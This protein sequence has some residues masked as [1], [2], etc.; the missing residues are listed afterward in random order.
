VDRPPTQS[1]RSELERLRGSLYD[2]AFADIRRA[3]ESELDLA[4]LAFVGLASWIDTL[5]L[6][7]TGGKGQGPEAWGRFFSR[8]VPR[9]RDPPDAKLLSH[10]FRNALLHEYGTRQVA[11]THGRPERHW[12]LDGGIRTLDLGTLLDEFDAAFESFYADLERDTDLRA[13]AL[14]RIS[15]LLSPVNLSPSAVAP[16][17]AVSASPTGP[18]DVMTEIRRS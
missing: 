5:S 10:G 14:P 4:R 7:F 8:Y 9:Y 6:I 12:A 11:L 13:R 2:W 3:A 17:H 1:E 16:A 15:G 18:A